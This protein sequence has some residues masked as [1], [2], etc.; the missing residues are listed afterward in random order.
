MHESLGYRRELCQ[1]CQ[2]VNLTSQ[3]VST[4]DCCALALGQPMSKRKQ[5]PLQSFRFS[6]KIK[7]NEQLGDGSICKLHKCEDLGHS[8]PSV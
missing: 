7:N 5:Q 3:I 2:L 8:P 4:P 6:L 1:H